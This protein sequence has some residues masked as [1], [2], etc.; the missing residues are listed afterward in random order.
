MRLFSALLLLIIPTLASAA[1]QSEVDLALSRF[2]AVMQ[3]STQKAAASE[4]GAQRIAFCQHCHGKDGN[5]LRDYIPNI[6]QQNPVY[7]FTAF[8]KFGTGERTDFVMSKLAKELS[9]DDRINI[10]VYYSAQQVRTLGYQGADMEQVEAG[11]TVYKTTC[12]AC[13]GDDAK[14]QDDRPRLAGQPAEYMRR[15]LQLF[16]DDD[17]SRKGSL[18][19]PIAKTL[20]TEKIEAVAAYLQG[21]K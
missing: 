7:L 4:A 20:S 14:G 1:S 15:T 21:L 10:A 12:Y 19:G 17:P 11:K 6:A 8:E 16:K 18:M 3:N 9:L 2:Q 5:S 13:H